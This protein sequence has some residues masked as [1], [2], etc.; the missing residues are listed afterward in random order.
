VRAGGV[1]TKS[2]IEDLAI[3]YAS[4]VLVLKEQLPPSELVMLGER[5]Q[6]VC[7]AAR[8][9]NKDNSTSMYSKC[10]ASS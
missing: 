1:V 5:E 10:T 7:F 6:R 8:G 9:E 2:Q 3:A 4:V